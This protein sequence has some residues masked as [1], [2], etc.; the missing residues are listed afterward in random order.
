MKW[1]P[2]I[3]LSG[4]LATACT[5]DEAG[6]LE[7][8]ELGQ[9]KLLPGPFLDAQQADLMYILEM[10]PDRLLSPFLE[11]AG[12]PVVKPGYG[13]WESGGLNGHIGGHYI[14]ALA[15]MHAATG[16]ARLLER[17]GYMLNWLDT[18]Q[19]ANGNGYIGG[20]PEGKR[21][22]QE[23]ADGK[24]EADYFS[25]NG[26]WVPLYNIHKLFAGLRDAYWHTGSEQ[27]LGLWVGLSDWWLETSKNLTDEQLQQML[28]SEHG[29]LNE[30]FADLYHETGNADYL[31]MAKK[32]SHHTLLNPLLN[33]NGDALTG[34]HANTQIPKV[35]GYQRVSE[36]ANEPSWHQAASFFWHHV[37][38]RRTVAFGG[39]SV[40]EHFH[41]ANDFSP[42]VSSEQGPETCN[43]YNMLRLSRMLYLDE[44]NPAYLDYYERAQYNHILS[45]QHPDGGFVYFTPARPR[46]YRVYSQ[47]HEGMWCCVG[48][49]L[50]NHGKYGELIYARKGEDLLV[51]LFIASELDWEENGL[52]LQQATN[53]PESNTTTL[54]L[55][56]EVPK[57]FTLMIRKPDWLAGE[58]D[59]AVNG[60]RVEAMGTKHY[61]EIERTWKTGD[62]I[63]V[64]LPMSTR[65]EFLPDSS[66][67][68]AFVHGPVMLAA[69]TDST[70]LDGL[71]AGD[72][73]MGHV[74]RGE[75]YPMDGAPVLVGDPKELTEN[76]T[77]TAPMIFSL[78]GKYYSE[79][80]EHL[81]LVPFYEIHEAR[82]MMYWPVADSVGLQERLAVMQREE[83]MQLALQKITVDAVQPGQQQ[84]E[85]DH[86]FKG[87]GT[88]MGYSN[89]RYWR[90]GNGWFTYTMKDP[91][92]HAAQL[93]VAFESRG[94][95]EF[96]ISI[97]GQ[98]LKEERIKGGDGSEAVKLYD[99]GEY[100][101][102][103]EYIVRFEAKNQT[104]LPHIFDVRLLK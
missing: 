85:A 82:Y 41:P 54:K 49:G 46:H 15:I 19:Q 57:A 34:M 8:F 28:K 56:L 58:A 63:T 12:L 29:G 92:Q 30:V 65:L 35:I 47:P 78:E 16:D 25:L 22:W 86:L 80:Y 69:V 48:S 104:S 3:L 14:S 91:G 89:E 73:R 44:E 88:T 31:E 102:S 90:S 83:A 62:E 26:G 71:W 77:Q 68:A 75:F 18:C 72:G 43:T 23:I 13:N 52:Q 40:W 6:K 76:L 2:L 1:L 81:K 67:W 9:V 42:M 87:E 4:L 66:S 59:L 27:A 99:L 32:L 100:G 50:E 64:A 60:K 70:D 10:D 39:N 74:A 79:Q 103:G 96:A 11:S 61:Y 33:G 21:I 45:S 37:V 93:R 95:H 94:N 7:A 20:I 5:T 24:I 97:N 55:T 101:S 51:N 84:P 36:L 17:L 53:F 38:E 98:L